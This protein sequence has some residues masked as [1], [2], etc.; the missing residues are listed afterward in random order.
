MCA[1]RGV[2]LSHV[3]GNASNT[4]GVAAVRRLTPKERKQRQ[5][6]HLSL[7][8]ELTANGNGTRVYRRPIYSLA[9]LGFAAG[10]TE[11][12]RVRELPW[13]AAQYSWAGDRDPDTYSTLF[14][15]LASYAAVTGKREHWP[16]RVKRMTRPA[17]PVYAYELV[18]LLLE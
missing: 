18:G 16:P 7:K 5:E 10:G 4:D 9:V 6:E 8:V 11:K 1:A 15:G 17:R 13:L 2:D 3:G 12:T 14:W